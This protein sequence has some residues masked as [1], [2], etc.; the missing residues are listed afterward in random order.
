MKIATFEPCYYMHTVC[1]DYIV[2]GKMHLYVFLYIFLRWNNSVCLRGTQIGNL[3][4][5]RLQVTT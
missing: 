5:V 2:L 4:G 3:E 1:N